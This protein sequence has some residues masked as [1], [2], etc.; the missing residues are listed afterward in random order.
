MIDP[1][2]LKVMKKIETR[3]TRIEEQLQLR[4]N[5]DVCNHFNWIDF[6]T[7]GRCCPDCGVFMVDM[8]D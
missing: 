8:G 1:E 7:H 2:L 3:L 6:E 4:T 5:R